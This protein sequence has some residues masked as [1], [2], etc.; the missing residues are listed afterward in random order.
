MTDV[1]DP[2]ELQRRLRTA[3]KFPKWYG[4]NWDAF[5]DIADLSE[6][7]R[8]ELVGFDDLYQACTNTVFSTLQKCKS[9]KNYI[10]NFTLTR[11]SLKASAR[12]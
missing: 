7:E 9:V 5:Y 2:K 10:R 3:F 11:I 12:M 1:S 6:I 8:I 4:L